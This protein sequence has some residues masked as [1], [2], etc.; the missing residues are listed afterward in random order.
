MRGV[1]VTRDHP[2]RIH[3]GR[4]GRR[5][6]RADQGRG[7]KRCP[8]DKL[9][10]WS[11]STACRSRHRLTWGP[12]R[13]G[14]DGTEIAVPLLPAVRVGPPA[15]GQGDAQGWGS[16]IPPSNE[17]VF[18]QEAA[19]RKAAP[20][21][22]RDSWAR[23]LNKAL[24]QVAENGSRDDWKALLLLPAA[25]LTSA[26]RGDTGSREGHQGNQPPMRKVVGRRGAATVGRNAGEGNRPGETQRPAAR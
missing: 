7:D 16:Q 24:R 14:R 8:S 2:P 5:R 18:N 19:V 17:E 11:P 26:D 25:V 1:A 20:P 4:L 13:P 6:S 10:V 21:G 23:R 15:W 9:D 12:E 3:R 22:A